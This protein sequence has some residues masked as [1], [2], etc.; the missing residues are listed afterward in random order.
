MEDGCGSG[1][2][3]GSVDDGI[4]PMGTLA[5][6]MPTY[7]FVPNKI[8]TIESTRKNKANKPKDE[9]EEEKSKTSIN[10]TKFMSYLCE[11]G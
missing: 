1:D 3:G 8:K 7:I 4:L 2:S 6:T 10:I 11:C 9:E 5:R